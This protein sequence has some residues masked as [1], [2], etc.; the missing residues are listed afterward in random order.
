MECDMGNMKLLFS[1]LTVAFAI[2]GLT[3]ALPY[4][5]VMPI[6][7]VCLSVTMFV[8]SVEYKK[9]GQKASAIHFLLLGLFLMAVTV[10]NVLSV[11]FG[12]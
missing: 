4:N 2:L 7:F 5:I 12:I 3:R 1:A 11:C 9:K 6:T 10:Y 8:I